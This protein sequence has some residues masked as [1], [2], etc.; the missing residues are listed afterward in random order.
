MKK[1]TK[2]TVVF[3]S[4]IMLQ[5]TL[6]AQEYYSHAEKY[7]EEGKEFFD[8]GKNIEALAS[9]Q[10]S[11]IYDPYN[12]Y[13]EIMSAITCRNLDLYASAI[14]YFRKGIKTS[15]YSYQSYGNLGSI[16]AEM[17]Y[18]KESF[19]NL[20]QALSE[21]SKYAFANNNM[22][23][24]LMRYDKYDEALVYLRTA[25]VSDKDMPDAPHNI[26]NVYF[27]NDKLDSALYYYEKALEINPGFLKS[28][29][30]KII[31][32]KNMDKPQS[33]Y[34]EL[35]EKLIK[36]CS[37]A[38]KNNPDN[39]EIR[40]LRADLYSLLEKE[41][42]LKKDLNIKL[43]KLDKFVELYPGAYTFL[44]NRGNTH[45]DLGNKTQAI[46][47]Y[48]KVLEIN[49]EFGYVRKKLEKLLENE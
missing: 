27:E 12:Y 21:N 39:Y 24:L 2:L 23:A 31:V 19:V 36:S 9:F 4:F 40:K 29:V 34:K 41:S 3:F 45:R 25:M 15:G 32:M 1:L 6:A 44:E 26:G 20:R 13:C 14:H 35:C 18:D 38:L 7:K 22:G 42:N 5:N 47:D 33:E 10:T 11:L 46:A 17:G 48:R 8:E 30:A 49:P 16:Q 43:Q 28:A 37:K